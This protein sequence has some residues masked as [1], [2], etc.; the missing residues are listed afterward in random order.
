M[1]QRKLLDGRIQ[2]AL[3]DNGIVDFFPIQMQSL[4]HL[5]QS[6]HDVDL[7]IAAPTGSGKT[8]SYVLPILERLKSR[9]LVQLRALVVVPSRDLA[10]QVHSVFEQYGNVL[11]LHSA[12]A[13]G[14][15]NFADEQRTLVGT[16]GSVIEQ[17]LCTRKNKQESDENAGTSQVDILVCTPGRLVD[18][19]EQTP[20]FTLQH[21]QFLVVDEADRLLNQSYQDWLS[22][23]YANI[24]SGGNT[25][26]SQER[27]G[28]FIPRCIRSRDPLQ[29]ETL[30]TPLQRIIV[31][32]TL[33]KN[34]LHLAAL[35]LQNPIFI[36][37]RENK[38]EN[39]GEINALTDDSGESYTTSEH[40]TELYLECPSSEKPLAL[41]QILSNLD[42]KS[43]IIF[44]SSVDSTHR[45]CR[46][47][48]LHNT[49]P[50]VVIR[51]YTSGLTQKAKNKTL[52]AFRKGKI[53]ILVSS[54]IMARGIDIP[55]MDMVINYDVPTCIKTYIHRVGRTARAGREGTCVT[56]VKKGQLKGLQRMLAKAKTKGVQ[57]LPLDANLM[58]T[59]AR[60][61]SKALLALKGVLADEDGGRL[62]PY[63]TI[64]AIKD[65][66]NEDID[67]EENV[68]SEE[69][70]VE[71]DLESGTS[72]RRA[73]EELDRF[74]N[75]DKTSSMPMQKKKQRRT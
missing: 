26:T 74:E 55:N 32:A 34:P 17:L 18:H 36:A 2:D 61:Y 30:Y 19:L 8:L 21:V 57:R 46:L 53:T 41:L 51:E 67:E 39:K 44:A 35:R 37:L 40:L 16:S 49:S 25:P 27:G 29:K 73:S 54:D 13:L 33:N 68:E 20:G 75:E 62:G 59:M 28:K 45:L 43:G 5:L 14:Q 10:L 38:G 48:Q 70:I 50:H 65:D 22:L 64:E 66:V 12:V 58:K 7:C 6:H 63:A 72:K 23:V 52:E 69:D 15:A 31:S 11:G 47:L 56:L 71:E 3:Q 1:D 4:P 9:V 24:Y 42:G 60:R